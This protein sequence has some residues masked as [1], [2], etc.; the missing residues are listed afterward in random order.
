MTTE[1]MTSTSTSTNEHIDR[2]REFCD[3]LRKASA[4]HPGSPDYRFMAKAADTIESHA[5]AMAARIER[6]QKYGGLWEDDFRETMQRGA[7]DPYVEATIRQMRSECLQ[8]GDMP[9]LPNNDGSNGR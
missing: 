2:I 8:P 4:E 1:P 5:A 6:L 7:D 9:D 3:E